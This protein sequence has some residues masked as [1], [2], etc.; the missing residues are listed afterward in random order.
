[1][2]AIGYHEKNGYDVACNPDDKSI[3]CFQ[4]KKHYKEIIGN[5]K[6]IFKKNTNLTL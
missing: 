1:M 6:Y 3:N 5:G 4:I 2:L